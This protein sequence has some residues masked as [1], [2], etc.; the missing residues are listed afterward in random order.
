MSDM[1][2]I[3]DAAELLGVHQDTLRLWERQ[4][5]IKPARTPGNHRRYKKMELLLLKEKQGMPSRYE[6]L[7]H[8]YGELRRYSSTQDIAG[9][10]IR[11]HG[12]FIP[13]NLSDMIDIESLSGR[14]VKYDD[15]GTPD[16]HKKFSE[17][18]GERA[19][20]AREID[21]VVFDQILNA[22]PR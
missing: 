19:Y 20:C 12:V 4:G 2:N 3:R 15:S 16:E 18:F 14:V 5:K 13:K 1:I 11:F 17:E 22:C 10:S 21:W 7:T 9:R 8:I 6:I